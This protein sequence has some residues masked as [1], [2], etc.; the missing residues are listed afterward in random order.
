VQTALYEMVRALATWMAPILCFTA[1][2]VADELARVTGQAFDVHGQVRAEVA[3]AGKE[4]KNP[5]KRW[6]DEVRPRRQ[7]ILRRSRRSA[8]AGH[9]SLE[10]K[11]L[12]R[13]SA[14]ERPHWQWNLAHL[15]ELCVVSQIE[16][17]PRTPRARP[18][19]GDRGA[20]PDCPRCWRRTA[21]PSEIRAS[22]LCASAARRSSLPWRSSRHDARASQVRALRSAGRRVD[23]PR[24]VDQ[25]PGRGA[26]KP[27][28]TAARP[29]SRR[30]RACA[31]RRT[32][33]WR[34]GC[35]RRCRVAAF[36]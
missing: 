19:S 13:P 26:L 17:A 11:A 12:V 32:P 27:L 15:L 22:P 2:D 21:S 1:Q 30:L 10:A 14:A 24:S 18:R 34:S 4:L 7:A 35:C 9:K 5:N 23:H 29:S 20:R 6:F 25:G 36:C 16:L 8:P 31:T 28:A 33:G 3:P